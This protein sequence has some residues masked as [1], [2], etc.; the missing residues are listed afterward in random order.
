MAIISI[1]SHKQAYY[2]TQPLPSNAMDGS[3]LT[4][5]VIGERMINQTV[6]KQGMNCKKVE[7]KQVEKFHNCRFKSHETEIQ[8]PRTLESHMNIAIPLITSFIP[9]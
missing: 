9:N 3:W 8:A 5:D 1:Y 7:S 2:H 6:S 4:L